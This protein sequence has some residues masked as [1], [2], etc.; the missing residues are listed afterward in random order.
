VGDLDPCFQTP[1]PNGSGLLALADAVAVKSILPGAWPDNP[2]ANLTVW[3]L[4]EVAPAP[5]ASV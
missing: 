4:Y 2:H 1:A 3:A 5:L